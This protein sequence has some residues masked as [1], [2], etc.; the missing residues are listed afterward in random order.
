MQRRQFL[1]VTLSSIAVAGCSNIRDPA[2]SQAQVRPAHAL[3]SDHSRFT[4]TTIGSGPD[5]IL[6][7]GL[8]SSAAVWSQTVAV[9]KATHTLHLVQIAGMAGAE[10]AGNG[11]D[12]FGIVS[13]LAE[14]LADYAAKLAAPPAVIGHSMGG[15][16]AISMAVRSPAVI[17]KVMVID[18][19]PFFSVLIDPNA[20]SQG[21]IAMAS[22]AA[23]MLRLQS[24]AQFEQTQRATM[25]TLVKSPSDREMALGWAL[26]TDRSVMARTM[27]EV[28]T[29]DMRPKLAD[30]GIPMSVVY[31]QDDALPVPSDRLAALYRRDY[32]P[33]TGANLVPINNA[34]HYV[35]LDQP[36]AFQ[37]AVVTFLAAR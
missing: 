20:T 8:G 4:V 22:G 17:S 2:Q 13:G 7:H 14:Q 35:M 21:M 29:T 37:A 30:I 28:M 11:G 31:A 15:L 9:L 5:V 27:Q 26:T 18:V 6:V 16:V 24:G 3:S 1:L 19:L 33:V 32:A 25:A 10:T 36:A 12:D 23:A 34:L